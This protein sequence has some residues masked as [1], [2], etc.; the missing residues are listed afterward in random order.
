MKCSPTLK[1]ICSVVWVSQAGIEVI[2]PDKISIS[3]VGEKAYGLASL[4]A[5]WTLPY[6]VISDELF[7]NYVANRDIENVITEWTEGVNAAA[8]CC[9]ILPNDQIIVRSNA[10]S[11]G[12]AE[13]GKFISVEGTF[14]E[15]PILVKQ[16]F[17]DSLEQEDSENIHMPVIIQKRVTAFA[18]GHISNERR[19][20]EEIR[21]WKGEIE[22][23]I[24]RAFTVSLRSWRKK[25]KVDGYID[26]PLLCPGDKVIK[27]VLSIPCTWATNQRIRVHFEWVY[28]G[29]H[30][31]L[32]QADEETATDGINPMNGVGKLL[33]I[34]E[35]TDA[36]FPYCVHPLKAEDAER[37]KKYAKIQ[38]PL[39]YHRIEQSTAPLYILDNPET[40]DALAKGTITTELEKDLRVLTSRSLIIRTD[41]ATDNKEERQLLPRTNG[42]KNVEVAKKWLY[43]SCE[44]LLKQSGQKPIFIMHNYIPAFSSAFA[45][46]SPGDKLVRI[47]ALWGLPEG[48]Y[49]YSHDKHVVDTKHADAGKM[50]QHEFEVQSFRNYKKYFVFPMEDEKWEVQILASPYDWNGAIPQDDWIKEIAY[51]T[52][53]VSEEEGKSVSVMWFVGVD[54]STYGCNV[55][56]WHHEPFEYN[57]DQTTPRNK[58]SF[59]RTRAIHTI[60]DLVQLEKLTTKP[61]AI[62]RNIQIQPTDANILRDRSIIDRIGN[63]AKKLGANILLEGGI[64]SHAYYQLVRTGA[65][66]E[67]RHAFNKKQ[68]L[69]FNKLVR[70]KIP[71]K[72]QCNGEEAVTAQLDKNILSQLLKRKLVEEALE[73]LDSE[74]D[75]DLV[76]ELA[77]ILEV[78]DG[79]LGQHQIDLQTVLHQKEKKREKAGGF[80]K[81]IYLRTTSSRAASSKGKIVI[82]NNPVDTQQKVS[83][84]TD[85]RKYS[86]ANESL[87][88]IKV[89]VTLDKWEIRP[90][91]RAENIDIVLRGERKQGT[92]QIE[93]SVFEEAEQMSFFDK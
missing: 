53:R 71:E 18:C 14:Q 47:E 15:W 88:R 84:S 66:V 56:P 32:V 31:Y 30:I 52:R 58:L 40:L 60:K 4:P 24:P 27:D 67:V 9:A 54:N 25:V 57:E 39:L 13:R 72:I 23:A 37:Y 68:S 45:Y 48:L 46:A 7:D 61:N 2:T 43:E 44:T 17:D 73:V 8:A 3:R 75:E 86:T 51:V 79:I 11:E 22:E 33:S 6:F 28:D 82:D 21:D 20:A 83:K 64:L 62:I 91:V 16:C 80:E 38:N 26:S 70:D 1:P 49:Y 19:V 5:K 10:H 89:P 77:D 92:W 41:I 93:I 50:A 81:G 76:V 42:I 69:E 29:Y 65:K 87:T 74:E 36:G 85:L 90:S 34:G 12:L 35:S 63:A 78:L 59:E 55:F